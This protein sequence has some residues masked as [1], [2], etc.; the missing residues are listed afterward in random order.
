MRF[1]RPLRSRVVEQAGH[2]VDDLRIP[3]R[4]FSGLQNFKGSAWRYRPSV[5]AIADHRVERVHDCEDPRLVRNVLT[6]ETVRITEPIPALV[7]GADS[8]ATSRERR[9]LIEYALPRSAMLAYHF[10][11]IRR[12]RSGLEENA[13]RRCNL[14]DVVHHGAQL[15]EFTLCARQAHCSAQTARP[16]GC[17][18]R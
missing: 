14:S 17:R 18:L 4:S 5:G 6:R 13:I 2:R 16:F 15:D 8:D 3:L 12:E 1:R 11:L 10:P 9:N 7:M